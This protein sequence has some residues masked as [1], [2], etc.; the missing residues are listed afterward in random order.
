MTEKNTQD[1][2]KPEDFTPPSNPYTLFKTW[3]LMAEE[4]EINDH[5]AMCLATCTPD[6]KPSVRMVLLKGLDDKGLVFYTNA[7]SRKGTEIDNNKN[8]AICF[9]W[10]SI[11]KQVRVEGILEEVSEEEADAY[12]NT[13]HRGSR[14][15]AWASKQ[16]QPLGSYQELKE[17]VEEYES[18]FQ[19][20]EN[21]PRPPYWKGFRLKPSYFEFW[22]D[23]EYRLHQRYLYTPNDQGGWAIRMLYP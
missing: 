17:F 10:K 16:S 23:G 15:G 8:A 21:I 12:Y 11:K 14:V 5:N 20:M 6:G 7:Q 2:E 4:H 13:R 3:L 22:I 18:K 9:H 1:I 19:D